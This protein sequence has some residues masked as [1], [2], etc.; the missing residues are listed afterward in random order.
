MNKVIQLNVLSRKLNV[1]KTI[2][3]EIVCQKASGVTLTRSQ[4]RMLSCLVTRP[5]LP[6]LIFDMLK[7]HCH[8]DVWQSE[9]IMPYDE[10]LK[11]IKG[12]N[13]LVCTLSDRI[14]SHLL[15]TATDSLRVIGTLSVGFDHIDID[16]CRKRGIAVGNTPDVL[17]D[18]VA[19]LT[20]ALLLS[21]S[22]RLFEA[23]KVLKNG[24]WKPGWNHMFMCGNSVK[25]SVVGFVGLGRIGIAVLQ[26][27]IPFK[28]KQFLYCGT[29]R[30][31]SGDSLGAQFVSFT[32][33]LEKSDFIIVSCLLNDKT[34]HM[35]NSNAFKLMKNTAIL[36]NTS[37]GPVIDQ[38][39]LYNALNNGDIKG[40][41]LDVMEIEPIAPNDPLLSL[42]NVVLLPHI[43]SASYETRLAM[44]HLTAHNV[45]AGLQASKLP[46]PVWQ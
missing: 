36:I 1:R 39:A 41:G 38:T 7:P 37:R 2:L 24:Q 44:A 3:S 33:L 23:E 14:D 8:L 45:I 27:L 32:E 29:N 46:A 34:R 31:P 22:R 13:A 26:R 21:T 15:N 28:V 40:A 6:A 42:N 25:D 12:K 18:A 16:E 4:S 35:F 17:T 5:D 20:I 9:T 19:E 10:L 11:R 43:G 30:K